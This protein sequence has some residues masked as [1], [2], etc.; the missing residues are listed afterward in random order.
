MTALRRIMLL[1]YA[2]ALSTGLTGCLEVPDDFDRSVTAES[3]RAPYPQLIPLG[4]VLAAGADQSVTAD[5]LQ[6]DL[7]ARIA[8]MQRRADGLRGADV[9]DTETR[10]RLLDGIPR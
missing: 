5:T 1:S 3:A 6:D 7:A 8:R 2:G 4:P 10:Q 9:L